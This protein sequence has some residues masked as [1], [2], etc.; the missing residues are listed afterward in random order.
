[1]KNM[2]MYKFLSLGLFILIIGFSLMS[3]GPESEAHLFRAEIFDPL[4]ITIAPIV[5]VF[6]YALCMIAIFKGKHP[7]L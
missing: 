1:M 4:N 5:L 6:A 2:N 7:L 3:I